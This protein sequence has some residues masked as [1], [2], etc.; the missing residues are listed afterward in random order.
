M[1]ILH[2]ASSSSDKPENTLLEDCAKL[3]YK[4]YHL[5]QVKDGEIRFTGSVDGEGIV[6]AADDV[7]EGPFDLVIRDEVSNPASYEAMVEY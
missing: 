1:N 4:S 7:C 2:I 5:A 6:T 3:R